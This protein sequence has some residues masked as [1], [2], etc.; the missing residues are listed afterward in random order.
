[1]LDA[2]PVR[3]ESLF[4]DLEG[5]LAAW[6]RAERAAEVADRTRGELAGIGVFD[7][8]RG[9][10]GASVR[11]RAYGVGVVAGALCTVGPD[12][13]LLDEGDGREIVLALEAVLVLRDVGRGTAVP[14]T[15]GVVESRL[16]LRSALRGIARD[17]A[18]IRLHV[19]DG[20][21]LDGTLDRVGADFVEVAAHS[22]G[23]AR[24]QREVREADIVP[25][26]ALAALR[27]LG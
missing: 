15:A 23:E 22:A 25:F 5:Q 9:A 6:D 10:T 16:G 13:V 11:V 27:R 17:R 12:W 1:M 2:G 24:R 19:R 18:P 4:A 21:V 7:R 8:L 3:W 14:G 26:A 20:S